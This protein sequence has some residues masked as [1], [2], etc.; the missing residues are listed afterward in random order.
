MSDQAQEA[1]DAGQAP[2]EATTTDTAP[3][4]QDGQLDAESIMA[5]LRKVRREA[6]KYRTELRKLQEAAQAAPAAASSGDGTDVE[7]LQAD[8]AATRAQMAERERLF[9]E[10][11]LRSAVVGAAARSGFNDPEDAWR[12]VDH[13][14]LEVDEAGQVQGVED[15]LQALRRAKPYLV[16]AS[17]PQVAPTNPVGQRPLTKEQI[18]LMSQD[19]INRRWDEVE[20]ALGS[21]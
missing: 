12:M 9:Q 14:E 8:L 3:G 6:A 11:T 20:K 7:R 16:R 13:G 5:E 4:A 21:A 18:R 19:E 17:A 10:Q 1:Q 2:E 15:A